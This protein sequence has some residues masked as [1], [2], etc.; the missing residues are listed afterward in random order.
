MLPTYHSSGSSS[1]TITA[2]IGAAQTELAVSTKHISRK[3]D[4]AFCIA[5]L[6]CLPGE[7]I[8]TG[9]AVGCDRTHMGGAKPA[10]IGAACDHSHTTMGNVSGT[11]GP[12][13]RLQDP[14]A[15]ASSLTR[16][17]WSIT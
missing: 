11:C 6:R 4:F 14:T 10:A 3:R 17:F 16:A 12:A 9:R 7:R 2:S 5:D 15:S 13:G 1:Q 8:G